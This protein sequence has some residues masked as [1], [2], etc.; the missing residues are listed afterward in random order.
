M[1]NVILLYLQVLIGKLG[2][3]DEVFFFINNETS[4]TETQNVFF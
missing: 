3:S 1:V 2:F 4:T